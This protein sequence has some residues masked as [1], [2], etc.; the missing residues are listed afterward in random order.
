MT[1]D[2]W[3]SLTG[4]RTDGRRT[5]GI[6]QVQQSYLAVCRQR[7]CTVSQS[8]GAYRAKEVFGTCILLRRFPINEFIGGMLNDTASFLHGFYLGF[9][10]R[11]HGHVCFVT[12]P[13]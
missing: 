8:E 1:D 5:G 9:L 13:F 7:A 10:F 2:D 3:G 6:V 12:L 4:L 11:S